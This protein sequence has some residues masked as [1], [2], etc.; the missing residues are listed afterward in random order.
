MKS[1]KS[2]VLVGVIIA[3]V[4]WVIL[5]SHS[6]E[7]CICNIHNYQAHNSLEEYKT[8]VV[9]YSNCFWTAL[10][11]YNG[12]L[13][14][15]FTIVIGIF[16]GLLFVDGRDKG[17][18]ELRAYVFYEAGAIVSANPAGEVILP[19][20]IIS[21]NNSAVSVVRFKN[22]GQTPAYDC[23]IFANME[24]VDWPLIESSLPPI[25]LNRVGASREALGPG[26]ERTKYNVFRVLTED[27][28]AILRSGKKALFVYGKVVYRDAFKME[29]WTDFRLF[30]GGAV[31]IRDMSLAA[32][33]TGN[34]A[35][36]D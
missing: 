4:S 1:W 9:G 11:A 22:T 8:F 15:I 3:A 33:E 12:A 27:D 7:D 20:R 18:R 24:M 14:S 35:D 29:R 36:E 30:I 28:I 13:I 2:F 5:P 21:S 23:S 10:E 32:H 34:E 16:T 25:D 17:R 19:Q 6:F 31:G 26:T